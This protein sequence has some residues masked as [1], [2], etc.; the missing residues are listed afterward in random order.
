MTTEVSAMKKIMNGAVDSKIIEENRGALREI[1]G[2]F[3]ADMEKIFKECCDFS[4][5][6]IRKNG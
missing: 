6:S 3:S 5:T 2:K 4:F 1:N